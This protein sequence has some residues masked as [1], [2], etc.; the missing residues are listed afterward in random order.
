[1]KL[2]ACLISLALG[3]L[4]GFVNAQ[5]PAA[6][7]GSYYKRQAIVVTD[8]NRALQLYRDILGFKPDGGINVSSSDSYVYASLDIPRHARVR[9][10]ALNGGTVQIRTLLLVEVKGPAIR[11]NS[12]LQR[13][14]SVINANGRFQEIIAAATALGLQ[15]KAPSVLVSVNPADGSGV[16]QAFKDFDGNP[17]LLY[18]FPGRAGIA[19]PR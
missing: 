1:M 14:L 11:R 15:L 17:I 16:E 2:S 9:T 3:A 12:G 19:T 18:E 13:S 5:Q 4:G 10:T 7:A 8:I 6:Y